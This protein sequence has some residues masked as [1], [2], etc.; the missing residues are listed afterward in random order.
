M[1][2]RATISSNPYEFS[3]GGV[4]YN[5]FLSVQRILD[6]IREKNSDLADEL[7]QRQISSAYLQQVL[8]NMKPNA[9]KVVF[10][11]PHKELGD[12]NCIRTLEEIIVFNFNK[13]NTKEVSAIFAVYDGNAPKQVDIGMTT[14]RVLE[15]VFATPGRTI[16]EMEAIMYLQGEFLRN[17]PHIRYKHNMLPFLSSLPRE[18]PI[19]NGI[20]NKL[21]ELCEA[22]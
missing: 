9:P 8:K 16:P 18:N 10:T 4:N 22:T 2:N 1:P 11:L 6:E 5:E 21:T 3:T 17:I 19:V 12:S 15:A 7:S 13:R 20:A 14:L